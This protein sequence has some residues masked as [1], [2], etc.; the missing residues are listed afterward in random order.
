MASA[1]TPGRA[2]DSGSSGGD[3]HCPGAPALLLLDLSSPPA[4]RGRSRQ[5]FC[6]IFI[7]SSVSH[8][9]YFEE[10]MLA[11]KDERERRESFL[12]TPDSQNLP[13][14]PKPTEPAHGH[15]YSLLHMCALN[16]NTFKMKICSF[17]IIYFKSKA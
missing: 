8:L 1:P 6:L 2:E 15:F 5:S 13:A 9:V 12:S 17:K 4:K 16:L 10:T 3:A 14:F 11:H 7:F